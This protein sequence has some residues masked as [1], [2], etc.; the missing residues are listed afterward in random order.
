MGPSPG[1]ASWVESFGA[2]DGTIPCG[3]GLSPRTGRDRRRQTRRSRYLPANEGEPVIARQ[4][5]DVGQQALGFIY[6][7]VSTPFAPAGACRP[8]PSATRAPSPPSTLA[9]Y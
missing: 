9:Q 3:N 7:T 1:I 4:S 6:V 5:P 8:S 2:S